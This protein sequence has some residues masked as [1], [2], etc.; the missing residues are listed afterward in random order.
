MQP[1]DK[2]SLV[3]LLAS[4]SAFSLYQKRSP[5]PADAKFIPLG[6]LQSEFE[7]LPGFEFL[8]NQIKGHNENKEN[9]EVVEENYKPTI[10]ENFEFTTP[11]FLSDARTRG[12]NG[13]KRRS[14]A[15]E[16]NNDL[17]LTQNGQPMYLHRRNNVLCAG[18]PNAPDWLKHILTAHLG[19]PG[20]HGEIKFHKRGF[21]WGFSDD[22]YGTNIKDRMSAALYDDKKKRS[23]ASKP[24]LLTGG[25]TNG[26]YSGVTHQ[27]GP[28]LGKM[29][30]MLSSSLPQPSFHWTPSFAKRHDDGELH[31]HHGKEDYFDNPIDEWI[32]NFFNV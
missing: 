16:R 29:P 6:D 28:N 11:N 1:P 20:F 21:N 18:D 19:D 15:S 4:T 3:F 8:N 13:L 10:Y 5:F 23:L 17:T 22:G 2:L 32:L 31:N 9:G 25:H 26:L 27:Y 24:M 30:G 14:L 7:G 12:L